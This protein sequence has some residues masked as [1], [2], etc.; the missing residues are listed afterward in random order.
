VELKFPAC[1]QNILLLSNQCFPPK[2]MLNRSRTYLYVRK[3]TWSCPDN[4]ECVSMW[5]VAPNHKMDF[6]QAVPKHNSI[7]N[8]KIV[9]LEMVNKQQERKNA[10]P[11]TNFL[12][13][14]IFKLLT[15]I[16]LCQLLSS[17]FGVLLR[18]KRVAQ[19]L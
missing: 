13:N 16:K 2:S 7:L 10:A 12:L 1:L 3:S 9:L 4:Y 19:K 17:P 8:R 14:K 15:K 11:D 18:K 5:D 6:D